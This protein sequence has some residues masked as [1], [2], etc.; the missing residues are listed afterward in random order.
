[1]LNSTA[2][3]PAE[4]DAPLN[5]GIRGFDVIDGIKAKMEQACPGIVSCADIITMAARDSVYLVWKFTS[6]TINF[7]DGVLQ[8][9]P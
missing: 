6:F 3:G 2:N 1:M 8:N 5:K 4:K 9:F 7:N